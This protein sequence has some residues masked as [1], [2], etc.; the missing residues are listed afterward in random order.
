MTLL[1]LLLMTVLCS[2]TSNTENNPDRLTVAVSIPPQTQFAEKVCGERADILT[3][4]PGGYS[5]ETYEPAPRDIV[6]LS[7]ADIYFTIGVPAEESNIIPE[8]GSIKTVN[9]ASAIAEEYPELMINGERDPHVWLS[10]KRV[11]EMVGVM[12]EEMGELDPEGRDIYFSNAAAYIDEINAADQYARETL[13]NCPQKKII[14][15]HPAFG[16]FA[17]EY[18]LEMYALEDHGKEAT[19]AHLAEM[20]N[21]AKEENIKTVFY[22]HEVDPGQADAFAAEIGGVAVELSPLAENYTENI[23]LMADI[24]AK[25]CNR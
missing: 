4:I 18:G 17:D 6:K 7:N 23:K 22:Q 25:E 20:V 11:I 9:L 24:I 13:L 8:A 1:I 5:P 12:A 19:A 15:Y 10:P 3:V 16:Y 2:C 14:V 21:F